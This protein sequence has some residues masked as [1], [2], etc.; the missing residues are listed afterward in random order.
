[1][2]AETRQLE[3]RFTADLDRR[4]A[5]AP[6]G[7]LSLQLGDACAAL[8]EAFQ[9]ASETIPE[10]HKAET[11]RASLITEWPIVEQADI[12]PVDSPASP[13]QVTL[14]FRDQTV[15]TFTARPLAIGFLKANAPLFGLVRARVPSAAPGNQRHPARV[16]ANTQ[17]AGLS[18]C[19]GGSAGAKR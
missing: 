17:H 2:I 19:P 4:C 9:K 10:A 12:A 13:W 18:V 16:I 15:Q 11:F 5:A 8:H 14:R 6:G 3:E 1:M 7:G